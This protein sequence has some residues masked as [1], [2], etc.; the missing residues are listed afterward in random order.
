M[1]PFAY[2]PRVASVTGRVLPKWEQ[3]PPPW[4]VNFCSNYLLSLNDPRERLIVSPYDCCIF[5][6]HQALRR[7]AFLE[8][9]GFNPENTAGEWIGDGETGLNIKLENL[10]YWFA[11]TGKSVTYH[12]IPPHRMTQAYL[13]QRLANQGNCDSYTDYRRHAYCKSDLVK[14][15]P[16]HA[17]G[18]LEQIVRLI[19]K[20]IINRESW[21]LNRGKVEYFRSRIRYDIRLLT[22]ENWRMMASKNDW[23]GDEA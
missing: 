5:S 23:L 12:I 22:D 11:Y 14:R 17:K 3:Q 13:N 15:I 8:S 6:C 18:M 2:D 16:L 9:G 1:K 4:V 21:R 7:S 20:R 10:G 19:V